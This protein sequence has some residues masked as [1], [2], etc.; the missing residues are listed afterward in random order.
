ML[1]KK[2]CD[3]IFLLITNTKKQ[4]PLYDPLLELEKTQKKSQTKIKISR[5]KILF[6]TKTEK[7]SYKIWQQAKFLFTYFLLTG[8]IFS[9]LMGAINFQAYSHRIS[10]WINPN[11]YA[12]ST[13]EITNIISQSQAE[14]NISS[15]NLAENRN[16]LAEQIFLKNPEMIYSRNY[17]EES[18]L[19]NVPLQSAEK[20][21]FE[22]TPLENR[23]IIPRIGKNI[24]LIDVYHDHD[25]LLSDMHNIFMEELKKGIVRYPGTALPGEK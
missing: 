25:T 10:H 20:A 2:K 9:I 17:N 21:T 24:P 22:V 15:Q 12:Q 8:T 19:A 18:L 16:V 14:I 6:S 11:A 13:E 7:F 3:K 23:I 1:Q 5:A 4:M